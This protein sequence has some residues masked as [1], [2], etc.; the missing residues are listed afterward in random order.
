MD[1]KFLSLIKADILTLT[2]KVLKHNEI[3]ERFGIILTPNEALNLIN[4]QNSSLEKHGRI[5]FSD[6]IVHKLHFSFCDSSYVHPSSYFSTLDELVDIFYYFKSESLD[7]FSDDELISL[8]RNLF[9]NGHGSL[10]YLQ[11]ALLKN[12]NINIKKKD[13]D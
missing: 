11:D 6:G 4:S 8:M 5:N 2:N 10:T 1:T 9:E 12:I 7:V 13:I 3:S